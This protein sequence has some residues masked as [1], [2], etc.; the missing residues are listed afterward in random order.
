MILPYNVDPLIEALSLKLEIDLNPKIDGGLVLLI[1]GTYKIQIEF[2]EDRLIFSCVIGEVLPSRYRHQVFED[3][4]KANFK[5]SCFGTLGY[6][7]SQKLL[8]LLLN[9]PIIP[10]IESEFISLAEGFILKAKAWTD[11]LKG[12]NTRLLT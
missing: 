5:S 7:S 11:A 10:P 1:D 8:I 2:L 3:A 6:S 9:Y 12:S 4:L